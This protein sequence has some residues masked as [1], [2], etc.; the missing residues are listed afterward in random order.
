[1]LVCIQMQGLQLHPSLCIVAGS[2]E[3]QAQ[4]WLLGRENVPLSW[5]HSEPGVVAQPV[6]SAGLGAEAGLMKKHTWCGRWHCLLSEQE[7]WCMAD[8]RDEMS[9]NVGLSCVQ[10]GNMHT[11]L[12][13]GQATHGN[14]SRLACTV[15]CCVQR[16]GWRG[17]RNTSRSTHL[18]RELCWH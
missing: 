8:C 12:C 6:H 7:G 3:M 18:Q 11:G 4:A 1:M 10:R 14:S 5:L 17:T 2:I 15:P 9:C 16:P 13:A